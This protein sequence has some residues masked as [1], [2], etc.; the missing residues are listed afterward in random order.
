MVCP[1]W[2][3][4]LLCNLVTFLLIVPGCHL[5]RWDEPEITQP[6][7]QFETGK[8]RSVGR[9]NHGRLKNGVR[10]NPRPGIRLNDPDRSWGTRETVSLICHAVDETQKQ[11]PDTCDLYI[12]D[13]SKKKGGKLS[14]HISHQ[15]GRDADVG[16][17]G[18]ENEIIYFIQINKDNLDIE[19][20]WFFIE[21]LLETDRMQLILLD[22]KVQK[23]F[24]EYLEPVYPKWR[25]EKYFQYPRPKNVRK[26]IIRHAPGH[27][28]HLHIR[29]KCSQGDD[30]C[31]EW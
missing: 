5:Q 31:E 12:G 30:G 1:K 29:F 28:N 2:L 13:I 3:L 21:T 8:S 27:G 19:K 4:G 11:Y 18:K 24:Y 7:T 20:T 23:I 10:L 17:Y 25:L 26:G 16:L 6:V 14:P 9:P 15:S 22:W